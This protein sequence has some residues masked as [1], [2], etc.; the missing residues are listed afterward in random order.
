MGDLWSH[1]YDAIKSADG[2]LEKSVE[3]IAKKI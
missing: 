2:V 1:C 3:I